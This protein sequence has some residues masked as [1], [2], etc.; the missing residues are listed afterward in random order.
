MIE[1]SKTM[2]SAARAL[3]IGTTDTRALC[4]KWGCS[5]FAAS[6]RLNKLRRLKVIETAIAK[7]R[8][9]KFIGIEI[10]KI[11]EYGQKGMGEKWTQP[12]KG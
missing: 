1:L 3:K 11:N 10:E 4:K 7:G 8:H 5:S 2:Y 9:G 6:R 12:E